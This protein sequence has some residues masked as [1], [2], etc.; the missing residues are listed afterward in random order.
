LENVQE[1]RSKDLKVLQGGREKQREGG[2]KKK[3]L[4][5]GLMTGTLNWPLHGASTS[6]SALRP[7]EGKTCKAP[8]MCLIITQ[9]N[10]RKNRNFRGVTSIVE[11]QGKRNR[12]N[13]VQEIGTRK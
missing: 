2:K 13:G 3:A 12:E 7:K 9:K 4:E 6:G 8:G 11:Y 5:R 10:G 1:K